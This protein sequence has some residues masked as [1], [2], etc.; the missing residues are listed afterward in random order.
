MFKNKHCQTDA[1]NFHLELKEPE[2]K[3]LFSSQ[4]TYIFTVFENC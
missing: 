1:R 2:K 4:L 3:L